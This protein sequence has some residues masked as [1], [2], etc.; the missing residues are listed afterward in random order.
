MA[1]KSASAWARESARRSAAS[2]RL[3]R[4]VRSWSK[5]GLWLSREIGSPTASGRTLTH[6]S[7]NPCPT[8]CP[9]PCPYPGPSSSPAP[10]AAC[11]ASAASTSATFCATKR[12]GAGA[13]VP[14]SGAPPARS[15]CRSCVSFRQGRR[16][17][18]WSQSAAWA[19]AAAAS[20]RTAA[21]R[22]AGAA[23]SEKR[24]A[25]CAA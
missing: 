10:P 12:F 3:P 13:P 5:N 24:Q 7:P 23:E 22:R 18:R 20:T 9:L 1:S 2:S 8:P 6:P 17:D 19:L 14:V 15:A 11:S 21:S 4:A 25:E 16:A